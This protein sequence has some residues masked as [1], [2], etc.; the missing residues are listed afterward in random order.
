MNP[1]FLE[2]I[3]PDRVYSRAEVLAKE[4]PVPK[5]PGVYA[6]YFRNM[7]KEVPLNGCITF[8]TL[9]LLY[10]GIS[11]KKPPLNKPA[12]KQTIFDRIRYHMQGNAEGSTLRLTLGC[13][14][15]DS[16]NIKL[17][18]VGS[19][20][21]ITFADGESKLSEWMSNNAFVVWEACPEPWKL[22]EYLISTLSLPLNLDQN[23]RHSYHQTLSEL[24]KK[25]R[26]NAKK[27]PIY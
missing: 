1:E 10:I 26:D 18:R 11:P 5:M 4:S 24:R 21:R 25:A 17:R 27:I 2:L 19:G 22:E 7:P 23:G 6:W 13:I 15:A 16:L 14:L 12:S 20:K 3:R 8:K 9:S